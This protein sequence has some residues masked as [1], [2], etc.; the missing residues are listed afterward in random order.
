MLQDALRGART[1]IETISGEVMRQGQ[2]LGVP[3]PANAMLYHLIRA[4]EDLRQD[5]D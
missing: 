1:E 3:T 5:S 4:M 2:K